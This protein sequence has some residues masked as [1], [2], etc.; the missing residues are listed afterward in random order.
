MRDPVRLDRGISDCS[1]PNRFGKIKGNPNMED[2]VFLC[3]FE[4]WRA[5]FRLAGKRGK[6]KLARD[7]RVVYIGLKQGGGI[8]KKFIHYLCIAGMIAT[9]GLFMPTGEARE[10]IIR[11]QGNPL[12]ELQLY[13]HE[14]TLFNYKP[15]FMLNAPN[16]DV[17][18]VP[19][20]RSRSA[21][22]HETGFVQTLEGGQWVDLSFEETLRK[23]FPKMERFERGGGWLGERIVFDRDNHAYT[24]VQVRIPG[25]TVNVLLYSSDQCRSWK[26]YR[27]PRGAAVL[28]NESSPEP[29]P[30]PPAIVS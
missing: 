28:E 30:Y 16:F 19:Y 26:A 20:I 3:L 13:R 29:M 21:E 10:P 7:A 9:G 5:I 23:E 22:L 18:N 2:A 6:E 4:T 14:S 24:I 11:R 1:Y 17:N 12:I 15:D 27:L 25:G 8:M